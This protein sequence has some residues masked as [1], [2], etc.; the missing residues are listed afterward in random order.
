MPLLI[1]TRQPMTIPSN[2]SGATPEYVLGIPV[3]GRENSKYVRFVILCSVL[4]LC[5]ACVSFFTGSMATVGLLVAL[6]V[7]YCGYNGAANNDS[8][9]LLFFSACMIIDSIWAAIL[10][11][12]LVFDTIEPDTIEQN[13]SQSGGNAAGIVNT[14]ETEIFIAVLICQLFFSCAGAFF[15]QKLLIVLRQGQA[16]SDNQ[17]PVPATSGNV[18][19]ASTMHRLSINNLGS[20][21]ISQ[22]VALGQP[23]SAA[24]LSPTRRMSSDNPFNSPTFSP[25]LVPKRSRYQWLA[26]PSKC[27]PIHQ[28][29]I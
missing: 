29:S 3:L 6:S 12:I 26:S 13:G 17:L 18:I 9:L 19:G 8:T 24:N 1:G 20:N 15:G 4:T 14:S 25:A 2:Q 7:S 23:P 11:S 5:T 27:Q 10:I 22:G 28:W 21:T 16:I